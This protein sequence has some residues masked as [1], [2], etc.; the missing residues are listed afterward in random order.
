MT[1]RAC[2]VVGISAILTLHQVTAEENLLR[3]RK[4]VGNIISDGLSSSVMR[5]LRGG[6]Q[7]AAN[8]ANSAANL[9]APTTAATP[10]STTECRKN[11]TCA[12]H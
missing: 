2:L 9:T 8:H 7:Q 3:G 6:S 11:D 4:T 10:A 5:R 12:V 1:A